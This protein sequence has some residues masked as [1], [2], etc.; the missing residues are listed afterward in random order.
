MRRR[1]GRG[2]HW[3][4]AVLAACALAAGVVILL[5]GIQPP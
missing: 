3:V 2:W 5:M 1:P 4:L